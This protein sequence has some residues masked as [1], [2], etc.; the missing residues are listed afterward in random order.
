MSDLLK[1]NENILKRFKEAQNRLVF[2]SADLSLESI[3]NMVEEGAIDINPKYQRRERWS[4]KKQSTLIESFLLNIPVP[5]IF[6]AEDE[7][8]RYSVID[9]K[10][11][12]TSIFNFLKKNAHLSGLENYL[13]IEGLTFDG[14]PDPIRNALRIRPYIRVI[15]LL[16][17]SDPSLKYEV[18]GRLNTGGDNLLPQE[19]RNAMFEGEFND[20]LIKL[21]ENTFLVQQLTG[22]NT[23]KEYMNSRIYQEMQDVEYVLRFFTLR[24]Y[25]AS[26]TI[27]NMQIAMTTFMIEVSKTVKIDAQRVLFEKTMSI[28]DQIWGI[29][30]FKRPDGQF[31]KIIQGVFDAQTVALSILIDEGHSEKLISN[32]VSIKQDFIRKYNTDAAFQSSMRQF[33][34]NPKNIKLRVSTTLD[35]LRPHTI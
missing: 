8:G 33:T 24:N 31:N 17:Q 7:Y 21:S 18:F 23:Q 12:I 20:L 13:E 3:A 26:L 32:A 34:S 16:K 1:N 4:L 30:A 29:G 27:N 10:Q 25:W 35:I 2:Q 11:R 28:A 6:L 14:L 22:G 19:V 15:T 5:P 9:G